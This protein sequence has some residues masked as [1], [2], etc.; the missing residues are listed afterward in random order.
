MNKIFVL[1][2]LLCIAFSLN[3]TAQGNEI[4]SLK[5]IVNN[6]KNDTNT[7]NALL[8]LAT[9]YLSTNVQLTIDYAEQANVLSKKLRHSNGYALSYKTIARGQFTQ[10]D[11]VKALFKTHHKKALILGTGGAPKAVNYALQELNIQP[12][13]VSRNKS[14]N[15]FIYSELTGDI[16]A[17]YPVII[18][19]TPTGMYPAINVAPEIPYQSLSKN[20]LLF[21]LIYNPEKTLFLQQ[22]EK[23][24]SI[25]KNGLEMLQLQAEYAWEI[26]NTEQE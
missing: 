13:F 8:E 25:I 3:S 2:C 18:N 7:V 19:C 1:T 23:Q 10:G 22:G 11:Y 17:E 21:D 6:G 16:I 14:E 24:G 9:K 5:A 4:D 15:N 12:V 20:N 26:W